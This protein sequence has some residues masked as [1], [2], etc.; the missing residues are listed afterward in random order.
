MKVY[1]EYL[2]K[3]LVT[4]F[5]TS[6]YDHLQN[7]EK[8]FIVTANPESFMISKQD[9]ILSQ[10]MTDSSVTIVADGIGVVKAYHKLGLGDI[11]KIPGVDIALRMLEYG[12]DLHKSIYLFGAHEEVI[13]LLVSKIKREYPNLNIVGFSNG[14]VD[15]RN[16][17]FEEIIAKQPDMVMVAL[18]VPEQEKLI[19]QYYSRVNKG[20]YIGVGGSFD[21]ISGSKRRA[22]RVFQKLNL[23][24]LYRIIREPSRF[25]RFYH[26][27]V[28]FVWEVW[29]SKK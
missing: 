3:G 9:L 27:N 7:D 24:W 16:Q 10:V 25:K 1:F 18:G 22:P 6:I 13:Q 8:M 11:S 12:N 4:D 2:Y 19:A 28:K 5:Y 23:E 29:K 14:Y 15:D 17:I 21:V 20:I 26:N